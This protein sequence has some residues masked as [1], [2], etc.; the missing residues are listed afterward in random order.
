MRPKV[1]VKAMPKPYMPTKVVVM[2]HVCSY[3]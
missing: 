2:P 1:C 3:I